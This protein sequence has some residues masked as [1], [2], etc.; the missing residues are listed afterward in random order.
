MVFLQLQCFGQFADGEVDDD[1]DDDDDNDDDDDDIK[2]NSV[3]GLRKE[4][5]VRFYYRKPVV[6]GTSKWKKGIRTPTNTKRI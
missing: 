6:E 4:R 3:C 2:I 1:D 5:D